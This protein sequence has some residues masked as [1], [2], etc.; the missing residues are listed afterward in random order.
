M[1]P[2]A[3][4]VQTQVYLTPKMHPLVHRAKPETSRLPSFGICPL[5]PPPPPRLPHLPQA[6]C[7]PPPPTLRFLW[8]EAKGSLLPFQLIDPLPEPALGASAHMA[9]IPHARGPAHQPLVTSGTYLK[10]PLTATA[11]QG[12][13]TQRWQEMQQM[14]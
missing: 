7:S 4:K 9:Q 3:A 6:S 2:T 8:P 13:L 5:L 14:A 1:P 11:K 12:V 10:S